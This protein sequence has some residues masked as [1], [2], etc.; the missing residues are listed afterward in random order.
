MKNFKLIGTALFVFITTL[1]FSAPA[2]PPAGGTT[3]TP[4][5]WPPPCVPID[6]GIIFLIAGGLLFVAKKF[7]DARKTVKSLS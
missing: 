4:S 6:N 5:C 1:V 2:P 3:G 7:Y